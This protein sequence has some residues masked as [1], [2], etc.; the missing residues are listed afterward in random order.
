MTLDEIQKLPLKKKGKLLVKNI[1]TKK[2][3][4]L[5]KKILKLVKAMS[6]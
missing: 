3:P 6:K 1:K 5:W 2:K 4:S